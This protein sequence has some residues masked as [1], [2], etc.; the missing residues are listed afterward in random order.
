MPSAT[1]GIVD[2]KLKDV[3][4]VSIRV[5]NAIKNV[6]CDR[7]NNGHT[8]PNMLANHVE[9]AP[10]NKFFKVYFKDG[11][12][13]RTLWVFLECD[14][15]NKAYADSSISMSLGDYGSSVDIMKRVLDQFK[16]LG[17][18]YLQETNLLG[19]PK[20]YSYKTDNVRKRELKL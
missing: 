15:D 6:P 8:N 5:L 4:R 19:D 1:C 9:Y 7:I 3:N 14:E 12:L 16:D 2:T 11:T 20:V 13:K 10:F 17:T 18:C